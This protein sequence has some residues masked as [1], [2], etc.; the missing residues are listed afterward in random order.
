MLIDFVSFS[1]NQN[2]ALLLPIVLIFFQVAGFGRN[3]PWSYL[4]FQLGTLFWLLLTLFL[5]M[6]M[7]S[8]KWI[9]LPNVYSF[10]LSPLALR[11]WLLLNLLFSVF[12]Y[13]HFKEFGYQLPWIHFFLIGVG[14]FFV[15]ADRLFISFLFN[16]FFFVWFDRSF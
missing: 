14:F 9:P 3:I 10:L 15:R 11:S 6:W 7:M 16:L 12:S 4:P 2:K 13:V 1:I 8:S 5:I